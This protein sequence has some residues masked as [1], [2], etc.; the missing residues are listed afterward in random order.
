KL[1]KNVEGRMKELQASLKDIEQ[2]AQ[3]V[4]DY[5]KDKR[6]KF[7]KLPDLIQKKEEFVKS[8][9]DFANQLEEATRKFNLK[10]MELNKQKRAFDEELIEFNN[11]VNFFSNNF[12]ETPVYNKYADIIERAEPK[13]TNYNI[14][15]LCTQ[16]LKNDSH[17]N[18][19]YGAFQRYVNE[20][21]GKFRIDNHFNF[22]IR[23]DATQGEYERFAQNLRSFINENKIEMSIAETATQIGLVTDSIATKVKE[24]SGQKEKIQ[25]IISLIAEDFKKAEFEES[26]LIEFIK[27]KIEES[28]N[29][30]YKLLKRIEE[31]REEHGLVYNEGLFNTDFAT[32]QK[33]EISGRAVK[34]LEQLRSA[35]KEQEQEE[36]R[37]QDLFELKFN[38]KE[39]MNETGWTN[40]IDSIGSTGTDILVKAIIYITLL[41]VFIKESSHRSS[42]DFKVHC[43]ID[44]VGQISAHYLRE[45]LKF[46]KNRN[47]MMINGLPNKSGLESHYKY[48]YQFRREEGGNVRVFPSIVTEVEA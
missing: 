48:T 18:E 32:G 38:I 37:L 44:E 3:I 40:K 42:K 24:L 12:R 45:L 17:F 29:K 43:I 6:E 13:R 26:K 36:I 5:L 19:E 23:N 2:Y 35:I 10:R 46:A 7:D 14:M 9:L 39:G 20:F 4:S 31:F 27:I 33:R 8:N 22:V 30:V 47:I 25:H 41:H 34:L 1:L 16:L 11:G 15:D 28:D 21:A